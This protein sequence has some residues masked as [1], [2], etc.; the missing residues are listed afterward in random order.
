LRE[1]RKYKNKQ[2]SLPKKSFGEILRCTKGLTQM[3]KLYD[4]SSHDL[5]RW[6]FWL[7]VTVLCMARLVLAAQGRLY[8]EPENSPID[9]QM[10]YN[11]AVSITK[12]NWL[13]AY[14]YN[15]IAK[16]MF[17]SVWL[18]F[19]HW[20]GV[21]YL[22]ANALLGIAAALFVAFA[23][24]PI[25]KKKTWMIG[26]FFMLSCCP[27][28]F[29][30]YNY[31]VYRDSITIQL[32][33]FAFGGVIGFVL[34]WMN[35]DKASRRSSYFY[36]IV[37]GLGFG[38]SWLNRED[39]IWL[40]PFCVCFAAAG[41]VVVA[42]GAEKKDI[43]KKICH[44]LSCCVVYT[45]V[46]GLCLVSYAGMNLKTYGR[47][48]LSDLTSRDFTTAYGLLTGIEDEGTGAYRPITRATRQKLYDNSTFFAQLEP[49][50]ESP[51]VLNGYGNIET[52]EYN[53]SFYYALR[54][55]NQLYGQY[56]DAVQTKAFYEQI[57]QELLRLDQKGIISISHKRASTLAIWKNEYLLPTLQE[58]GN[59]IKMA[60]WL[61][62][63]CVEPT[64]STYS[65]QDIVDEM[66]GYMHSQ[67]VQKGIFAEGT[68]KPYYNLLQRM[69]FTVENN[70]VW[71]WRVGI[72]PAL[73]FTVGG[74][75]CSGKKKLGWLF[76]KDDIS[77]CKMQAVKRERFL[78]WLLI[79]GMLLSAL[80]RC[81]IM[82][83]MEVTT[84]GIGTHLMYLSTAT[85]LLGL[86]GLS[87]V[88]WFCDG[89]YSKKKSEDQ[90]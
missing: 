68:D 40:L 88:K 81:G 56:E 22:V 12:G 69:A 16:M 18:A 76:L 1:S 72:V 20:T 2:A 62:N 45:A 23:L 61:N 42:K 52:G 55:A 59:G 28:F 25:L 65:K 5:T 49:Y 21:P 19:V 64:F 83:Y 54:L 84:F 3:K 78:V 58:V 66:Q 73:I 90:S 35:T 86:A 60:V 82:A 17:F 13:G 9:D 34:R 10:M 67:I 14:A 57:V 85:P 48:I 53:G 29:D 50:W 6:G 11:A 77:D 27:V 87:G 37:G 38:T 30:A 75:V 46:T 39:G 89:L 70:I 31:R 24:A 47:F 8:L 51:L 41:V 63:L 79:C 80:L 44:A 36:A 32:M 4:K 43:G 26:A 7:C 15:T 33:L 74:V 71:I